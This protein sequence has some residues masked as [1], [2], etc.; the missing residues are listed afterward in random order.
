MALACASES[1]RCDTERVAWVDAIV[2]EF[3]SPPS[4][5]PGDDRAERAPPERRGDTV[6]LPGGKPDRGARTLKGK[7]CDAG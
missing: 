3:R 1:R 2:L 7:R 6:A 4:T 5:R